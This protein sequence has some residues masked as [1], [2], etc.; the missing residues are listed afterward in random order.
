MKIPLL[1]FIRQ[2]ICQTNVVIVPLFMVGTILLSS[3]SKKNLKS[4]NYCFDHSP[5]G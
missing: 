4:R 5:S 2:L 1:S 3:S